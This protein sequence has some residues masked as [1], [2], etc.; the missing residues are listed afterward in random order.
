MLRRH[1]IHFASLLLYCASGA[2]VAADELPDAVIARLSVDVVELAKEKCVETGDVAAIMALVDRKVMPIVDFNR[3]TASAVGRPWREASPEQQL[4]LQH[5][6]KTLLVRS[7]AG[8]LSE[9]RNLTISV[10]PLRAAPEESEVTVRTAIG[11]N[12]RT[13]QLDYRMHKTP[14]GWKIYDLNVLGVWLA[15]SFRSQFAAEIQAKGIDGLIAA[16]AERNNK[17]SSKG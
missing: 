4:R 6:F 5:E 14:D 1:F 11:S 7:Y 15:Q 16:L 12:A 10:R 17:P 3:M 9:A 2:A 8:V 13:I